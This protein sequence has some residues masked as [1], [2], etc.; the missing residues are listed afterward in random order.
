MVLYNAI[1]INLF[2]RKFVNFNPLIKLSNTEYDK[3]YL[4]R[5]KFK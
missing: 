4:S 3:K 1:I 2:S 5:F